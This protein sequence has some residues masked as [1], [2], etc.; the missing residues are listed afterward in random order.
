MVRRPKYQVFVSSTYGDL[1][2][3]REAVTWAVLTTRHIPVGMENFTAADDRGWQIIQSVIDRT[4]YYILILAGR[5]GSVDSEGQS[6][7]EKEYHYAVSKGIP[8]LAFIRTA[9][10]ITAEKL[11]TTQELNR[12]LE[13]F[14]ST[15]YSKHLCVEWSTKEELVSRVSNA[16]RN[17]I[18]DD[19]DGGRARPGWYRGDDTPAPNTLNEFARLS[20]ENVRLRTELESMKASAASKPALAL[21][22]A[23]EV[24]VPPKITRTRPLKIMDSS[25]E[26]LL[27]MAADRFRISSMALALNATERLLLGLQNNTGAKLERLTV[28]LSIEPVAGFRCFEIG[29]AMLVRAG[30]ELIHNQPNGAT[31]KFQLASDYHIIVTMKFDEITA[32]ETTAM[33]TLFVVGGLAEGRSVFNVAY[34]IVGGTAGPVVGA[35]VHETMFDRSVQLTSDD[36]ER[37]RDSFFNLSGV[38]YIDVN[39]LWL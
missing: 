4:D 9:T 11:E 22:D 18:D 2:E 32:N 12:K 24:P 19:E 5:Y 27:A 7:T 25:Q 33:P 34:R 39:S 35:F 13:S 15:V 3:E 14:K 23:F 8:V 6:W 30:G 10:S 38:S 37:E 36:I 16:L 21:V 31:V 1:R 29:G 17:H 28:S 20:D 26:T